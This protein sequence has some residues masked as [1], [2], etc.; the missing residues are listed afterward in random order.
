MEADEDMT[1]AE[2][3]K[4]IGADFEQTLVDPVK[5]LP[6]HTLARGRLICVDAAK[7]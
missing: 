6:K 1:Y 3:V 5:E 7:I 2:S 4:S